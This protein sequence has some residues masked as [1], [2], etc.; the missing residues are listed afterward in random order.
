MNLTE[1]G[2]R[3]TEYAVLRRDPSRVGLQALLLYRVV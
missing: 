3:G 2:A 1:S